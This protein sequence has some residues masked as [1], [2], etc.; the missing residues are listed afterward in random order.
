MK[1]DLPTPGT[2]RCRRSEPPVRQQGVQH[3]LRALRWSGQVDSISDG[4]GH[5]RRA[6]QHD[7]VGPRWSSGVSRDA[8]R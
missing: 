6:R 1:V 5:A 4:L 7:A 2:P 3:L 8:A